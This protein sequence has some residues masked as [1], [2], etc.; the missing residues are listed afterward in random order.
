[1]EGRQRPGR[2]NPPDA[3]T[4]SEVHPA[5]PHAAPDLTDASRTPGAGALPD[6]KAADEIDAGTG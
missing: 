4:T 5:G 2:P 3:V 6:P 1:V